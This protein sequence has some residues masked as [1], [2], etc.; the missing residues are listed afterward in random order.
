MADDDLKEYVPLLQGAHVA[1]AETRPCAECKQAWHPIEAACAACGHDASLDDKVT[2]MMHRFVTLHHRGVRI[3]WTRTCEPC[4]RTLFVLETCPG[5][6]RASP[7]S[8]DE[9]KMLL[10]RLGM[11]ATKPTTKTPELRHIVAWFR[12]R[13]AARKLAAAAELDK[14]NT[15]YG[16]MKALIAAIQDDNLTRL[17]QLL[18]EPTTPTRHDCHGDSLVHHAVKQNNLAMLQVLLAAPGIPIDHKNNAWET[19]LAVAVA[20]GAADLVRVLYAAMHPPTGDAAMTVASAYVCTEPPSVQSY[21]LRYKLDVQVPG[22]RLQT[23]P[24]KLQL[25]FVA[26][27]ALADLHAAG[28][29][30][31][32]FSSYSMYADPY[33]GAI[34]ALYPGYVPPNTSLAP[35]T[36]PEVR[37]AQLPASSA[38]DM[39]ALG[40]LFTELDTLLMPTVRLGRLR[41]DCES[42]YADLVA[43]CT[44][45]E[46]TLR[47]T[48]ADVVAR[49]QPYVDAATKQDK[50]LCREAYTRLKLLD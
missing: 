7:A 19:P 28:V 3:D 37:I 1:T 27:N 32:A 48:A 36:A 10:K 31:G 12:R 34:H 17:E 2:C 13:N 44:T 16:H 46:P 22:S 24:T 43:R 15:E 30:H 4:R 42:W 29:A 5:C 39:Y 49:L 21:I 40:V 38:S 33:A 14:C 23:W 11:A 9:L 41:D 50:V 8:K 47:L 25:A 18:A 35:W 26:A 20:S 45:D 6:Q